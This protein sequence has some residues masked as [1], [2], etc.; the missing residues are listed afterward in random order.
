MMCAIQQHPS[1]QIDLMKA[2][3]FNDQVLHNSF[4]TTRDQ[5]PSR[6]LVSLLP[7]VLLQ[8]EQ[9]PSHQDTKLNMLPPRHQ[10]LLTPLDG[11]LIPKPRA[12]SILQEIHPHLSGL[13]QNTTQTHLKFIDLSQSQD[14]HTAMHHK[15]HR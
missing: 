7:H 10:G 12:Q 15:A 4:P 3:T 2:P 5:S 9:D 1:T 11:P 8:L 13:T 6:G 14:Q